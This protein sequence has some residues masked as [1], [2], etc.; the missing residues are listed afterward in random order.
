MVG[1]IHNTNLF[2]CRKTFQLSTD[3]G[4]YDERVFRV[5]K[6]V[7]KMTRNRGTYIRK[8]WGYVI[9]V[10]SLS[11]FQ[12]HSSRDA[13]ITPFQPE[14]PPCSLFGG[15]PESPLR[16]EAPLCNIMLQYIGTHEM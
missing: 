2:Y 8:D 1:W 11:T 7:F 5:D 6:R 3:K 14:A 15:M 16:P 4:F 13:R 10:P 12:S 9:P